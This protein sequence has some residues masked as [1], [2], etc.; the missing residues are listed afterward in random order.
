MLLSR[1][2][3]ETLS[4]R[5]AKSLKLRSFCLVLLPLAMPGAAGADTTA[6]VREKQQ[7][8]ILEAAGALL[9]SADVSYVYGGAQLGN[10][11]A[12]KECNVCLREKSPAPKERQAKCP[13]CA[14]CSMDCSHFVELVYDLAGLKTNYLTTIDM[15]GLS[16]KELA[17]RANLREV[18]G[19]LKNAEVGDLLVYRGHVVILEALHGKGRGDVI[20]ATSGKD[21]KG[22]GQGIQ[23]ERMADLAYFRG[24]LVKVLR[25]KLLADSVPQK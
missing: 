16:S 6:P 2:L 25:H 17:H 3:Q 12:C 18:Q 22:P 23:R 14:R 21:N 11:D 9:D 13:A 24:A 15:G 1:T 19:A 8:R 7:A 20:H 5:G 4:K 10:Q